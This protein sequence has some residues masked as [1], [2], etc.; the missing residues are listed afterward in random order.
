MLFIAG[1]VL[2]AL[3]VPVVSAAEPESDSTNP[4]FIAYYHPEKLSVT[5][6]SPDAGTTYYNNAKAAST[7]QPSVS[8]SLSTQAAIYA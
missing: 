4:Q 8:R 5:K 6:E 7:S 2:L 3:F 1:M